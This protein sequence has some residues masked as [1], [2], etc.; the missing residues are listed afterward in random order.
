[1]KNLVILPVI[2]LMA[3]GA[4]EQPKASPREVTCK[5]SVLLKALRSNDEL[6][7]TVLNGEMSIQEA[8]LR[9]G[10]TLQEGAQVME[11]FFACEPL[12]ALPPSYGNKVL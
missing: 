1:M 4:P 8:V 11:D 7:T 3:C 9:A 6:I 12:Q 5:M 10:G 2:A